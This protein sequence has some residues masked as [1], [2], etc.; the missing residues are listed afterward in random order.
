MVRPVRDVAV[1]IEE[2]NLK[3][4]ST[5]PGI[6]MAMA[7]RIVAKLRRKMAK[8]A[9]IVARDFPAETGAVQDLLT[10]TYEA[11][12]SLGHTA[13][14]ARQKIDLVTDH[15]KKKFKTVEDLLAEIYSQK[16]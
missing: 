5:L 16:L 4:L 3:E 2:Q 6:G 1:A 7:E 15:G 12:L 10:E 14:D 8:F 13:A 9:L 11:L